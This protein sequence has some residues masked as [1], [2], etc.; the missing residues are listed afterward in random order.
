[1]TDPTKNESP[2]RTT[3]DSISSEETST[4]TVLQPDENKISSMTG[5]RAIT[6]E[7]STTQFESENIRKCLE[8]IVHSRFN[9]NQYK[10]LVS[11][12]FFEEC[13]IRPHVK[14]GRIIGGKDAIFGA[15][16]WQALVRELGE[17]NT[18]TRNYYGGVLIDAKYVLT[19]AHWSSEYESFEFE[20]TSRGSRNTIV[21]KRILF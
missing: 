12:L 16:P 2:I 19:V 9:S 10:L 15:W 8:F 7:G 3:N 4:V 6:E 21:W 1:M 14:S 17:N 11:R 20:H 13:G 18:F 5:D